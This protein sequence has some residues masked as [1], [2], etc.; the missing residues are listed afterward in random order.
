[1]KILSTIFVTLILLSSCTKETTTND[2]DCGV[3]LSKWEDWLWPGKHFVEIQ[4][5]CPDF[6]GIYQKHT[7]EVTY[8]YYSDIEVGDYACNY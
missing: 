2:C 7:K 5:N 3:V 1:M 6:Q 8:Q 4:D